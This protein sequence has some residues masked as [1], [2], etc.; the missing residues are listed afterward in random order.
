MTTP[1]P[2]NLKNVDCL[3]FLRSI[4]DESIDLII[5]DPPYFEIIGEK[6]DNQWTSEAAYLA[7]CDEWTIECERVLKQ[8]APLYVWGTTKTDTFLRYKLGILNQT[9]LNYQQWIIW[10]YNWGGR[11]KKKF[12]RKHEDLLAYSKGQTMNWYPESVEIPRKMTK[13]IRTGED[14]TNG[15]IPTCVWEQNNHTTSKEYC[16]WHPTQKPVVLLERIIRA[17][18]NVGDIVL[19]P[20]SGSGSTAIATLRQGR[21][22]HGSEISVEYYEK[23]LQRIEELTYGK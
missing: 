14:Y 17:H 11:T 8:G 3:E 21:V 20:F 9:K 12:P 4:P 19:D 2:L 22:F 5:A 18:T 7:W 6:W 23:S 16:G 13:N 1:N 15:T 10:S